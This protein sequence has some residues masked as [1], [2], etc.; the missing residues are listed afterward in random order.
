MKEPRPGRRLHWFAVGLGIPVVAVAAYSLLSSTPE[1]S[2]PP[3]PQP[4]EAYLSA[5]DQPPVQPPLIEPVAQA[6]LTPADAVAEPEPE[7]EYETLALTIRKGDTLD[8]RAARNTYWRTDLK[9]N[10]FN[11]SSKLTTS[12]RGIGYRATVQ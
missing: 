5:T 12:Y 4:S 9:A 2:P 10:H 3:L 11:V 7:A 6:L 8:N 1:S